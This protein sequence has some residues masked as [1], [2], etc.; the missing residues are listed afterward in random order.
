MCTWNWDTDSGVFSPTRLD[1]GTRLL[2]DEAATSPPGGDLLDLAPPTGPIA[3]VLAAR[4]PAATVWTGE[5]SQQALDLCAR[6]RAGRARQ[7]ALLT[8]G[9]P[10]AADRNLA[11]LSTL[12]S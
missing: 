11:V 7:R 5:V 8:A 1:A 3:L 10:G 6:R 12:T 9:R 4:A 2:L